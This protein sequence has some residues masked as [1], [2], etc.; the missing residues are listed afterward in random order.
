MVPVA[1]QGETL[2]QAGAAAA[3]VAGC[4]AVAGVAPL[5]VCLWVGGAA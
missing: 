1:G 5:L 4:R 3:R 2:P